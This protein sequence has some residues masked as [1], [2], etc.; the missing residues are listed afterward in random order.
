M[1]AEGLLGVC[2]LKAPQTLRELPLLLPGPASV[3]NPSF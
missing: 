1:I 2:A 3:G